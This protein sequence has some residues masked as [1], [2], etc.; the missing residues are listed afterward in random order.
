MKILVVGYYGYRIVILIY[1]YQSENILN[2]EF[3]WF[4]QKVQSVDEEKVVYDVCEGVYSGSDENY[5]RVEGFQ[6]EY[7]KNFVCF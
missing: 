6:R 4:K 5:V 1:N 7:K 2:E 3:N